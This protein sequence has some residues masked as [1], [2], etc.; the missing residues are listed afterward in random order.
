MSLF[1]CEKTTKPKI[2]LTHKNNIIRNSSR[3]REQMENKTPHKFRTAQAE[4]S[5]ETTFRYE[6]TT[7][8][9]I[10]QIEHTTNHKDNLINKRK[11]H[12]SIDTDVINQEH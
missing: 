3:S 8:K 6:T 4:T 10:S 11:M 7:D 12:L 1:G 9:K 5:S 2:E